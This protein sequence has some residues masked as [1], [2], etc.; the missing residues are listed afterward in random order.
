MLLLITLLATKLLS[1][2][3]LGLLSTDQVVWAEIKSSG[4]AKIKLDD[5][6]NL[7]AR[8]RIDSVIT[9]WVILLRFDVKKRW[10]SPVMV[11]FM[12]ALPDQEIRHLRILLKHGSFNNRNS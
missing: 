11:L 7:R 4:R 9:P 8:V 5:G 3:H 6:R 2:R 1:T 10:R 12:D